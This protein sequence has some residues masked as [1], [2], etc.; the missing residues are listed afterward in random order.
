MNI[1]ARAENEGRQHMVGS[2]PPVTGLQVRQQPLPRNRAMANAAQSIV[3]DDEDD[4]AMLM[5]PD[6]HRTTAVDE[7]RT[8]PRSPP[9]STQPQSG[10]SPE[11]SLPDDQMS[12]SSASN[13]SDRQQ[14]YESSSGYQR[15]Q[16]SHARVE[17]EFRS[18][19]EEK[20]FYMGR[21]SSYNGRGI[22]SHR[23]VSIDTPIEELKHEYERL[24]RQAHLVTSVKFQR[25][26]LMAAV[27]GAE[28]VNK[29]FNPLNLKLNGWS[30]SMMDGIE[31]YDSVFEQLHDKYSGTAEVAPEWQLLMMVLGS[32]FMFH[33]SNTLFRSVLPNVTDIAKQN[34]E[35]MQNIANAM[36]SAMGKQGVEGGSLSEMGANLAMQAMDAGS[37][38]DAPAPQVPSQ[39]PIMPQS[40]NTVPVQRVTDPTSLQMPKSTRGFDEMST[41]GSDVSAISGLSDLRNVTARGPRKRRKNSTADSGR[42]VEINL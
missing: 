40:F 32:G 41:E 14:P 11:A 5:N 27:T 3:D 29:K 31:E 22:P 35:L 18:I 17:R 7:D 33:L 42:A 23:R 25:R 38:A 4:F 20:Q 8:P 2:A 26:A 19:E 6:K 12:Y 9:W 10:A 39:P 36:S 15:E 24:K 34:P 30:E 1:I 37:S 21:I 16:Q 28:F 13:R